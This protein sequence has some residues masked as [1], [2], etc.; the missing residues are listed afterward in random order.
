MFMYIQAPFLK[1]YNN[2]VE[3]ILDLFFFSWSLELHPIFL[4]VTNIPPFRYIIITLS[5]LILMD[6]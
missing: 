3:T 5:I 6:V 2:A 1:I 4:M